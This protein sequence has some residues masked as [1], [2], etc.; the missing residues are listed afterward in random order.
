MWFLANWK[1]VAYVVGIVSL[2]AWGT[3][4]KNTYD[5][6]LR[7][8]GAA[9]LR[10]AI[11]HS[12]KQA[13]ELLATET[14]KNKIITQNW[15]D[16]ARTSDDEY[17]KKIA[18]LRAS[19]PGGVLHDPG[20]RDCPATGKGD[21]ATSES[22]TGRQLSSKLTAFLTMEAAR[23]DELRVWAQSCHEYVNRK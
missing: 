21:P 16:Y 5:K 9:P 1:L 3:Y 14:A 18:A 13:R 7:E 12:K 11:E 19:R 4:E 6:R 10:Q 17:E 22:S 23:A 20:S 2:L 15:I 8:E